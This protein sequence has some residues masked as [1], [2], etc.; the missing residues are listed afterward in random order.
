MTDWIA[1]RARKAGHLRIA[2]END[3]D[4]VARVV[5][6]GFERFHFIPDALPEINLSDVETGTAIFGRRLGAPLL[7]S[8]M[9]GGTEQAGALNR[10]LAGVAQRHRL[11]M[12]LGSGRVLLEIPGCSP[13]STFVPTLLTSCCLPTSGRCSSTRA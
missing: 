2:L 9:T 1:T 3:C 8:S 6:A 12:G 11:A 10:I 13:P 7:I 4:L 5:T